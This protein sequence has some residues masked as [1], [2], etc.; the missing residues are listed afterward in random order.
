MHISVVFVIIIVFFLLYVDVF[1]I[2]VFL[3][4]SFYVAVELAEWQR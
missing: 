4:S 3:F 1:D 2:I